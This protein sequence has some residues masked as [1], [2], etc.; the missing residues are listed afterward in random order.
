MRNKNNMYYVVHQRK[1]LYF[2]TEQY[3]CLNN[4]SCVYAAELLICLLICTT[5]YTVKLGFKE[6][7]G[8]HKKVPYFKHFTK[9]PN[10]VYLMRNQGKMAIFLE[11]LPLLTKNISLM[12]LVT[13][14]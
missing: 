13:I 14:T 11:S 7:F 2:Q 9:V 5:E 10:K 6:L 4:S 1:Y 12:D 3:L 8:H